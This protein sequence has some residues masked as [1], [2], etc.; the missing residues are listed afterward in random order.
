MLTGQDNIHLIENYEMIIEGLF[1]A[2]AKNKSKARISDASERKHNLGKFIVNIL[3]RKSDIEW[4]LQQDHQQ[5]PIQSNFLEIYGLINALKIIEASFVKEL[6]S[7]KREVHA[8]GYQ[9]SI[10]KEPRGNCLIIAPWNFPFQLPFILIGI[11]ISTGNTVML[12]LNPYS[13]HI[14]KI[15]KEIISDTFV[16]ELVIAF[17]G[18]QVII[19]KLL[20][21]PF[22]YIN[23][24]GEEQE[25]KMVK[26][27][28]GHQLIK[29]TIEIIGINPLFVDAH[30]D[31]DAIAL[32]ILK[33]KFLNAGQTYFAPDHLYVHNSQ[34]PALLQSLQNGL[35]I[36]KDTYT[37]FGKEFMQIVNHNHF[38]TMMDFY[39]D[40]IA[41]GAEA[42]AS[43]AFDRRALYIDP[44]IL[45]K[46]SQEMSLMNKNV[47]GPILPIYGYDDIEE[48]FQG[49]LVRHKSIVNL[50][51]FGQNPEFMKQI[52]NEVSS[53]SICINDTFAKIAHPEIPG[54]NTSAIQFL[55]N[56]IDDSFKEFIK[57]R[58]IM[59]PEGFALQEAEKTPM[60]DYFLKLFP[61]L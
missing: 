26:Q 38:D 50:Y 25:A 17:E 48:V 14:N 32:N 51:I 47:F 3:K 29:T 2:Q 31:Y 1:R 8:D 41:K 5:N 46:M 39:D 49:D 58:T 4:A 36:L 9:R 43:G 13:F 35:T 10:I 24:T 33:G 42:A 37:F 53:K 23:Y 57:E 21:L 45:S 11:S 6:A 52:I 60:L 59:T 34:L 55:K 44:I 15:I 7:E 12:N 27:R 22:D 56:R 16:P 30:D 40:A 19:E 28:A 20:E 61:K 18:N 54:K